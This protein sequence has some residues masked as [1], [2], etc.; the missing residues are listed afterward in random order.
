MD[1][2]LKKRFTELKEVFSGKKN[3]NYIELTHEKEKY[4]IEVS[5]SDDSDG[6][7]W[8]HRGKWSFEIVHTTEDGHKNIAPF[9]LFSS[10][11]DCILNACLCEDRLKT[12][13]EARHR[14]LKETA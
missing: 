6:I 11:D 9:C 13:V 1:T 12:S 10:F 8:F 7:R 14:A 5:R 2:E 4:Y 3:K